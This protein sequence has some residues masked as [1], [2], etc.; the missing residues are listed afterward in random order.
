MGVG[1]SLAAT[2]ALAVNGSETTRMRVVCNR[3]DTGAWSTVAG[4]GR[5]A[6]KTSRHTSRHFIP[7]RLSFETFRKDLECSINKARIYPGGRGG[8]E[9]AG[10][11]D[12]DW[13]VRSLTW[14]RLYKAAT[15]PTSLLRV[16]PEI[17]LPGGPTRPIGFPR[18]RSGTSVCLGDSFFFFEGRCVGGV[19]S[20]ARSAAS[21]RSCFSCGVKSSSWVGGYDDMAGSRGKPKPT[22]RDLGKA[23]ASSEEHAALTSTLQNAHPMA[24]ALVGAALV[25]QEL[26]KLL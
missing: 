11:S 13:I 1:F 10:I 12:L 15:Q 9:D 4:I 26:D 18:P 7:C 3:R 21:N 5:R 16:L 25:E 14:G 20:A 23:I 6:A 2:D 22:L 19:F 24:A 8:A 17:F